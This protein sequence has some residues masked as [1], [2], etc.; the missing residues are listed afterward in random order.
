MLVAT[1]ESIRQLPIPKE[2]IT[3]KKERPTIP[4]TKW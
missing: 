2:E 4:A 1:V 3:R